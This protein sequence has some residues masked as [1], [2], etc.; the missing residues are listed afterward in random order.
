MSITWKIKSNKN[1]Q[2]IV[3]VFYPYG[4]VRTVLSGPIKGCK[5]I[6]RPGMGVTYALGEELK[7]MSFL[8]DHIKGGMNV[9]DVGANIGQISL[10][11]S[12][13]VGINGNVY[14]FEPSPYD[15]SHLNR[16]LELNDMKNVKTL[17]SAIS[18]KNG[19]EQ[20]LYNKQM[21]TKGRFKSAGTEKFEELPETEYISVNTVSL[22][23]F[24]N[25]NRFPDFIKIDVE[26]AGGKVLKGA[27]R[28][29][30]EHKPKIYI[31]L[32]NTDEQLAV[33]EELIDKGYKAETLDGIQ[34]SDTTKSWYNP[35][36]CYVT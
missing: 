29:I 28:I 9:F 33:K 3:R 22:D 1:I 19:T 11:L 35:L 27:R 15:Y 21:N 14:S 32:H 20:F 4:S 12:G 25:N 23:N 24:A 30:R 17:N 10:Y 26:G 16:N 18:D 8:E 6:V 5:F 34:V 13:L 7:R 31:E 2:R 36:W